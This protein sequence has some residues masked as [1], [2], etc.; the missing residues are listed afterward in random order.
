MAAEYKSQQREQ[1]FFEYMEK[2]RSEDNVKKFYDTCAEEYDGFIGDVG[3]SIN[4]R[5]A[6][7]LRELMKEEENAHVLDMACGSGLSGLAMKKA[8]FT[9]F[10]G[11]DF[12]LEMLN[13]AQ[14]KG[15]YAKLTQAKICEKNVSG[16]E[17]NTYDGGISVF[18]IS[19]NY[20]ALKDALREF[21]RVIKHGGFAVYTVYDIDDNM[22]E[23]IMEEHG[24]LMKEKKCELVKIEKTFYYIKD[25][26]STECYLCSIK[27][28]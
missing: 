21:T 9:S 18:G 12:S 15:I 17:S 25:G 2:T 26:K 3:E 16:L 6:Y 7:H 4:E 24:K 8:G 1:E 19:K 28:L 11:V 20:I 22:Q 14:R 23:E 13:H 5:A 10:D 27:V